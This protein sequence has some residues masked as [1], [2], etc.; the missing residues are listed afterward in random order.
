M[1]ELKYFDFLEN[2]YMLVSWLL[3]GCWCKQLLHHAV[4][5][6]MHYVNVN[7][8]ALWKLVEITC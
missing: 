2:F 7:I 4:V 3:Y 5:I 1:I 6:R 8:T